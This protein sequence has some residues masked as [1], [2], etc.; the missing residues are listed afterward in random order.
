MWHDTYNIIVID[1]TLSELYNSYEHN[2][3]P[4]MSKKENDETNKNH[5]CIRH[6]GHWYVDRGSI[7]ASM[8]MFQE[9]LDAN[10]LI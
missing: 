9:G 8:S 1:M 10:F 3:I 2:L 7:V 4:I 5:W 6:A